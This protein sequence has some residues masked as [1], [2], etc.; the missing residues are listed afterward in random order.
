M[1]QQIIDDIEIKIELTDMTGFKFTRFQF[2]LHNS[3]A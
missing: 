3:E 2:S 1:P